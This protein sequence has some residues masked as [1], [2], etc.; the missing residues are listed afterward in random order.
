MY[1]RKTDGSALYYLENRDG[2][3]V[4]TIKIELFKVVELDRLESAVSKALER[5][6][7]FKVKIKKGFS[8]YYYRENSETFK[9][10]KRN[11]LLNKIDYQ[12]N[13]G[14]LFNVSYQ[15]HMIYFDFFHALTDGT[16]ALHFVSTVLEYYRQ[17][18]QGLPADISSIHHEECEN[19]YAKYSRDTQFLMNSTARKES[20]SFKSD[21]DFSVLQ[22]RYPSRSIISTAKAHHCTVTEFIVAAFIYA[23][24]K[25]HQ[26]DLNDKKISIAIPVDLRR[27]YASHTM[28]NFSSS[29]ICEIDYAENIDSLS[30]CIAMTKDQFQEKTSSKH[31]SGITKYANSLEES[32]VKHLPLLLK[33]ALIRI[34][35]NGPLSTS[36]FSNLGVIDRKNELVDMVKHIDFFLPCG[37]SLPI[38]F[39]ACSYN[40]SLS[41]NFSTVYKNGKFF[42]MINEILLGKR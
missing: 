4:F 12:E 6:R 10:L 38:C 22:Y 34:A 3:I 24:I 21:S 7:C 42:D 8:S 5:H 35:K 11:S 31:I 27:F 20:F 40:N 2:Q 28:Y 9:I 18:E 26:Q 36:N 23:V 37:E 14:F 32:P 25:T 13:N 41:L 1:Q 15:E 17:A 19:A 16:G 33:K 30:K 29:F 39:T